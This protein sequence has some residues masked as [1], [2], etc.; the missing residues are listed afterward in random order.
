MLTETMVAPVGVSARIET[1][2]P[3]TAQITDKIEEKITT[4]R[5]F[6]NIRIAESAGNIISAVI[7]SEPTNRMESTI[8]KAVTVAINKLYAP[9]RMPDALAKF[10]SNVTAKIL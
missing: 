3:K 10:S 1:I 6:L 5:K 7:K 9:A 4:A 8:T 2:S